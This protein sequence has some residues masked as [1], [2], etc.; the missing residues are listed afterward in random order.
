M[1]IM[2]WGTGHYAE[3]C[4]KYL[5]NGI[6]LVCYVESKKTKRI[7]H[8]KPVIDGM[9]VRKYSCDYIILAN[10]F[11][12]EILKRFDLPKDKTFKYRTDFYQRTDIPDLF[13]KWNFPLN[14]MNSCLVKQFQQDNYRE[15]IIDERKNVCYVFFSGNGIYSPDDEDVFRRTILEQDHYEWEHIAQSREI[16]ENAGKI[17]FVRDIFRSWY[18]NGINARLDSVQKLMDFLREKTAGYRVITCGNSAGG[19][20]S[21]I[22][23]VAL[24]AEQVF[25]V[26][27]QWSL[28]EHFDCIND[29]DLLKEYADCPE[30]N[31]FYDLRIILGESIQLPQINYLWPAN[32]QQDIIQHQLV[33]DMPGVFSFSFRQEGHGSSAYGENFPFLLTLSPAEIRTLHEKYAERV[34]SP[35]RFLWDTTPLLYFCKTMLKR[36]KRKISRMV[37][38]I[39][40]KIG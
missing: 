33:S 13:E 14:K 7:F 34:I 16:R 26:S 17:I 28:Y 12:D 37:H 8:G 5:K 3:L 40:S 25:D 19:Y 1:R 29:Y 31:R 20:M 4:T 38:Q 18:V 23:G 39:C 21:I 15:E 24:H 2:I 30:R 6:D 10:R 9:E 36:Q 27:G 35:V 22:G 32:S 11:E